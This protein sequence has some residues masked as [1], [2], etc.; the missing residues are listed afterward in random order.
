PYI[1]RAKFFLRTRSYNLAL[2][3]YLKAF[4]FN[5]RETLERMWEDVSQHLVRCKS[6]PARKTSTGSANSRKS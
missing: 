6:T 1:Y 2:Q 3:D 4:S 5:K